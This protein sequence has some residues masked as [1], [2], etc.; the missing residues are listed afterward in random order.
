MDVGRGAVVKSVAVDGVEVPPVITDPVIGMGVV[1]RDD[2]ETT[3]PRLDAAE[4]GAEIA[5]IANCGLVLPE[6]PITTRILTLMT[7]YLE[8]TR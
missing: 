4:P 3:A 1:I 5:V 7:R 8:S 6:S 2:V